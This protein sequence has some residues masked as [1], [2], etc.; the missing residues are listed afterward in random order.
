[1][2]LLASLVFFARRA[3]LASLDET[4]QPHG[5]E[6]LDPDKAQHAA[7]IRV[8]AFLG[9]A[10]IAVLTREAHRHRTSHPDAG[11][12]LYVQHDGLHASLAPVIAR[13]HEQVWLLDAEHWGLNAVH[14]LEGVSG[15]GG[16]AAQGA[17][18]QDA[19]SSGLDGC[20]SD[21]SSS[22]EHSASYCED[23]SM[24]HR[25]VEYH[26]YSERARKICASHADHGSLFTADVMLSSSCDFEGGRFTTT[27]VEAGAPP[28]D[29]H[30]T[31]EQ[32]DLLVFPAHKPHSVERVTA[33]VRAVFVVEF[34]RGPACTCNARCVG[35][36]G[37]SGTGDGVGWPRLARR[38]T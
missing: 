31:F 19:L 33:G 38:R 9:A 13:I 32:G 18:A 23:G 4:C 37:G 12:T 27:V 1:M 25:T 2:L 34:W 15:M 5:R 14:D 6:L 28:V 21:D 26:E 29:T 20:A 36:C 35:R 24:R 3:W 10:E 16:G 17:F 8:P 7:V 30:H 22:T 11:F